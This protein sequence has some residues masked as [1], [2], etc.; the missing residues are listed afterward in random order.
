MALLKQQRVSSFVFLT[1]ISFP[2][3]ESK[4]FAKSA[5]CQISDPPPPPVYA[6]RFA[7]SQIKW[8]NKIRFLNAPVRDAFSVENGPQ[9]REMKDTK[10][11]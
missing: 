4:Q 8:E 5:N 3:Y 9:A 11:D 7:E 6:D 10:Q 1:K 2:C